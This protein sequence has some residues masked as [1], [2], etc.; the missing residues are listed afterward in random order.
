MIRWNVQVRKCLLIIQRDVFILLPSLSEEN[1]EG[2][3]LPFPFI[4]L[5]C[6]TL[7][8]HSLSNEIQNF[9][10]ISYE[11]FDEHFSYL[12]NYLRF[13]DFLVHTEG[14]SCSVIYHSI[15]YV[16][17]HIIFFSQPCHE[18]TIVQVV[19]CLCVLHCSVY[20]SFSICLLSHVILPLLCHQSSIPFTQTSVI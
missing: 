17:F 6:L 5:L 13:L 10:M 2:N 15:Q 11:H 4:S 20:H 18:V 14:G 7:D 12:A 19:Q 1:D 9:R 8:W 16:P 3:I